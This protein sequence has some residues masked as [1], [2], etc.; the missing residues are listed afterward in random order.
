M[1]KVDVVI[2]GV[3][4]GE[5]SFQDDTPQDLIDLALSARGE[6]EMGGGT[7]GAFVQGHGVP[8]LAGQGSPAP[9]ARGGGVG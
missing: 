2:G 6:R 1:I 3:K 5:L 7:V 9:V 8:A 4:A